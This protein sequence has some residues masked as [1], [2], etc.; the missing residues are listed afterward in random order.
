M[1]LPNLL[2]ALL[3]K[4]LQIRRQAIAGART[5]VGLFGICITFFSLQGNAQT[6]Q[7]VGV[8]GLNFKR[9]LE[10]IDRFG[11]APGTL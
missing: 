3:D 7:P 9:G 1:R 10:L 4:S 6:H 11:M 8:L 2:Q 5:V